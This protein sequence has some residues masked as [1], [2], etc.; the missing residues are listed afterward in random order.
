MNRLRRVIAKV[1]MKSH[2]AFVGG[3][4]IL[5]AALVANEAID[6][7]KRSSRVGLVCKLDRKKAYDNVELNF[8]L[9]VMEKN[10]IQQRWIRHIHFL[11][12]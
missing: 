11:Y 4:P 12:Q 2:N 7:R 10:G 5:G 9:F 1:V 8:L 6:I 3:G